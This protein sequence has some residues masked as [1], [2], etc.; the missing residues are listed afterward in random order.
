MWKRARLIFL[1][2]SYALVM[3]AEML[4]RV[5]AALSLVKKMGAGPACV[6]QAYVQVPV[7]GQ[8]AG[9][10]VSFQKRLRSQ[11]RALS[12]TC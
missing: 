6:L 9:H 12:V 5:A 4:S 10:V 8:N 2:S 3:F 1:I 11:K 7:G